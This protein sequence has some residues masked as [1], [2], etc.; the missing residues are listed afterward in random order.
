MSPRSQHQLPPPRGRCLALKQDGQPCGA[1]ATH[2]S[3][4]RFGVPFCAAH[5]REAAA[6]LAP[7]ALG[8]TG[9]PLYGEFFRPAELQALDAILQ[10]A[11]DAPS[12][13]AEIEA[14]RVLLRRL[15]ALLDDPAA[16]S[17]DTLLRVAPLF[18]ATLRT[19][20]RL[21]RDQQAMAPAARDTFMEV[22]GEA[23]DEI[24]EEWGIRL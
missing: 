22:L 10:A 21:V 24:S 16:P 7:A 6:E 23:L 2:D 4:A 18:L 12:L 15:L 14:A 1:W 20:A 13:A 8:A 5:A 19:I 3:M 9:R 17:P 11:S